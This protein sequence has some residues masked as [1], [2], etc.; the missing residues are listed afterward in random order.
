VPA[1]SII[2]QDTK[3]PRVFIAEHFYYFGE[4]AVE[5]PFD[6]Q[7]LVKQG[8]GVKCSQEPETV[9]CFLGWLKQHHAPGVHGQP[10]DWVKD[11]SIALTV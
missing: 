11:R 5:I 10:G 4:N 3:H 9:N 7:R 8:R 6:Y 2:A 1:F